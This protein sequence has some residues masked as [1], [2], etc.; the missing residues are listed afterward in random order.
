MTRSHLFSILF[1][2]ASVAS[3]AEVRGVILDPSSKPVPNA[4]V[5]CDSRQTATDSTGR[6]RLD[7]PSACTASIAAQGFATASTRLEPGGPEVEIQLEISS[8]NDR[9]VVSA[10]RTPTT[11]EESGVSATVF[12]PSEIEQRQTPFVQDLLRD[13]AGLNI[14]VTGRRGSVSSIFTRGAGSTGTL[15]LLDGVPLN[16]PGGQVNLANFS[17][18][19]IERVEV[20]RGAESALFGAEAAAGV[21]QLFTARGDPESRRPRGSVS[22]ERGNLQTDRWIANLS[23]GFFDRLDYSLTAEQFH[24]SG[25]FANDYY[26]N[27]NGTANIGYRLT[28]KTQLRAVYREF[29]AVVGSPSQPG[30]GGFDNDAYTSDRSSTLSFRAD[31]VRSSKFVQRFSFNYNRLRDLYANT[32]TDAPV[33]VAALLQTA[34]IPTPRVY[35]VRQVSPTYP[36]SEVPPGLTLSKQTVYDFPGSFLSL[37]DRKDADYQGTVTHRGGALVFGYRY[38]RQGGVISG[39]DVDRTNNGGFV[40]EQYTIGRRLFLTGGARIENSTT[41]GTR[42][43]PRG[44]ATLKLFDQHGPFGSTY[45]RVSGGRGFTE[46]S[47]LQNFAREPWYVGNRLLKPEKTDMFDAGLVQ[48]L[49]GRRLRAEVTYF[50]NSFQDLIVYDGSAYPATWSNIDRSWARGVETSFTLRPMK[51]VEISGNYTRLSTR[52]VQTNSFDTY[53]GVGQELP[54]RPKHSGSAWVTINPRRFTLMVGGRAVSE[55][56]DSDFVYGVTRNPGFGTMFINASYRANRYFMPYFRV[57]NVLNESY[58]EVL[59]YQ[60]LKRTVL[61][62]VRLS[63]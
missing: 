22:Y 20:V 34:S 7:A 59:G 15:F 60:S 39:A 46:P 23:G 9:V 63:W 61:G 26:R 56:Q 25:M 17:T 6:F 19:G 29:D 21:V 30:W 44:S 62:G 16:E 38:D 10:T 1:A 58:Q 12:A 42:F 5:R 41:F 14:M 33:D 28:S 52:I 50:R 51:F 2:A 47:L 57:D 53:Q 18:A 40:H 13:A 45:V 11:L 8:R 43:V 3:A 54:R 24:N 37:T 32:L 49:F 36:A 27:T 55:R 35:L 31:D 4:T 48:E